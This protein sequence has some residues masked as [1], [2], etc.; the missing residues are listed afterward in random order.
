M[1]LTS[2]LSLHAP[3]ND[4]FETTTGFITANEGNIMI[5]SRRRRRTSTV[6]SFINHNQRTNSNRLV[7]DDWG[8]DIHRRRSVQRFT[9]SPSQDTKSLPRSL[10][11]AEY[12]SNK[13]FDYSKTTSRPYRD[14]GNLIRE[15]TIS[16]FRSGSSRQRTKMKKKL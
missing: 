9:A 14:P 2:H 4:P 13:S 5:Y 3:K 12:R 15:F 8:R 10:P 1:S 11:A 6:I 16:C 7:L